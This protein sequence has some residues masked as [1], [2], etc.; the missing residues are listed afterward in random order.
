[1]G[2]TSSMPESITTILCSM[3]FAASSLG[4]S[5]LSM[6]PS[7]R[8]RPKILYGIFNGDAL[9]TMMLSTMRRS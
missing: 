5:P 2:R 8:R 9:L 4:V 1:M 3:S 6:L 7:T